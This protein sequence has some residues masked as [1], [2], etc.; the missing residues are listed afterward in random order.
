MS[1]PYALLFFL[2]LLLAFSVESKLQHI[3]WEIRYSNRSPDCF[4]KLSI[5][6]NG[7]TPGPTITATEGDTLVIFATNGLFTEN[8]SIHWH[9]I[10]SLASGWDE[11]T[12]EPFEYDEERSLVLND[13]WHRRTYEQE[14]G[15]SSLN[16]NWIG[17]PDS[18]LINGRGRY[19][20]SLAG[21]LD[22]CNVTNPECS[23]AALA[24]MPGK[25]YRLRIANVASLSA[26]NLEIEGHNMTIVEADGHYVKPVVVKNL[27][28]YSGETYSVILKAEQSPSRNYWVVLN[29]VGRKPRTPTGT[30]I[31]NYYPNN[32]LQQPPNDPPS[33]PL[34]DDTMYRLN[35]SKLIVSH[36][37]YIQTPPRVPHRTILLLNSQSRIDGYLKWSLNNVSYF[38]PTTPYLIAMKKRLLHVFDPGHA[39]ESYDYKSHDIWSAPKNPNATLGNGIYRLE[40]G[41]TV[42]VVLQNTNT[43]TPNNSETHPWHLHGHDFW[44]LGYG[45]GKFDPEVDT[46]EYNLV[47]P[48]MKNTVALHPYGWTAIRF[49]AN[50]PGVWAFHCHIEAHTFM[51]MGVVFEEGV[52][53]VGKLPSSIMDCGESKLLRK[54]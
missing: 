20:C 1:S 48:I 47:D 9:G 3:K 25:T 35:Q 42:D 53:K 50:N 10:L 52:E 7:L 2:S 22:A 34:W 43:L 18:L 54:P 33:G 26:L 24:V 16:F 46:R 39:P 32:P 14:I 15:L 8:T 12:R 37:E 23:P 45:L 5:T 19:N 44:V 40:F 6:I 30:A 27:N 29:V 21:P 31:L 49:Q 36:P 38:F 51:G 41:S 28:T 4:T 11:G 17:E 13:W